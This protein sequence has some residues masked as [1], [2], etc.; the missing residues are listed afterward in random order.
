[1]I[2]REGR[3]LVFERDVSMVPDADLVTETVPTAVIESF[4]VVGD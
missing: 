1:M 4:D 3:L 2:E